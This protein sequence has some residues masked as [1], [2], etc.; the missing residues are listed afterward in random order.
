MRVG[1][2]AVL[3]SAVL[4]LGLPGLAVGSQSATS[5]SESQPFLIG[6]SDVIS[7]S[8]WKYPELSAK[9][10]VA[11]DGMI[12]LP[13]VG[14]VEAAGKKTAQLRAELTHL[15]EGFVTAP[16][17]SVVVEEIRSRKV[18]I[19]GEV[20]SSG[21]YDLLLPTTVM[22]ALALAGGLTDFARKEEVV[23]LRRKDGKD[24]RIVINIKGI[25]NGKGLEDNILLVPGDTVI[26]P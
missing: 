3:A 18:Y 2:S 12:S 20:A 8:V 6:V 13:L 15:Y 14:D 25:Q 17:V 9:I 16:A 23:V 19:L 24:E 10:P 4:G 7:V 22:Q 26:V 11:P 1:V 5:T 21:D